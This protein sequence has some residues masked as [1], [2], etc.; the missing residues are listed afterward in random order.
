MRGAITRSSVR[1]AYLCRPR[2]AL[3]SLISEFARLIAAVAAW[4]TVP[5]ACC[6]CVMLA[7][8]SAP[9]RT[10]KQALAS[11]EAAY[12]LALAR[13][14]EIDMRGDA[15]GASLTAALRAFASLP[16]A[17]GAQHDHVRASQPADSSLL[18]QMMTKVSLACSPACACPDCGSV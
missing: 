12:S 2:A 6:H 17:V 18:N 16:A 13:V 1:P 8:A 5:Q 9:L 3:C 15:D 10:V 14:S 4:R 7:H 11:A